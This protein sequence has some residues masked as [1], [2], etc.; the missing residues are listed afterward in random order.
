MDMVTIGITIL[1]MTIVVM[2]YLECTELMIKK[3]EVSQ[4]S[5]KYI[6]KMET[7]G[8]LSQEN[9]N[10]MLEE[11]KNLG[12]QNVDI[13]G[14]TLNP[15]FYGDTIMLRIKGGFRQNMLE[16][17]EELWNGGFSTRWVPLE[18][19]RMSTAKN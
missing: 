10:R 7:E 1:A 8:Y 18:E 19:I 16:R 5:R 2:V 11:L 9:K 14:T 12:L 15:V 6:L 13:S 4:V 3:M 17:K